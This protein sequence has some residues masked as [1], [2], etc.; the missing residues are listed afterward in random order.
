MRSFHHFALFR[1]AS[2]SIFKSQAI[3]C[4]L[5]DAAA[6]RVG[7]VNCTFPHHVG[8]VALDGPFLFPSAPVGWLARAVSLPFLT[9]KL[10]L[11]NFLKK[12]QK[13][14]CNL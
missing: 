3:F 11:K 4:G 2:F 8:T 7:G 13:K 5:K 1:S 9:V 10:L 12:F 6:I 14:T